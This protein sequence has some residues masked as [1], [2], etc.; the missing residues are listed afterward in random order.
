VGLAATALL[1]FPRLFGFKPVAPLPAPAPAAF[2][3][4]F[5]IGAAF[6]LFFWWLMWKR[7]TV[8]GDLVYYAFSPMWWGF[9]LALDG[10]AYRRSGGK[11]LLATKPRLLFISALVSVAGW[12]FFEFYDYFALANWYYPNGRM[13]QLSHAMIVV[14]FLIAYTTVWPAILEWYALLQTFPR[15]VARYSNGPRLALPGTLL[16]W[17]GLVLIVLMV[18]FPYPFFWAM[19]IGPL[20]ALSGQLIRKNVWSPFTAMAQGNWSPFLLVALASLFNGFF[21][22]IWNYGSAHPSP[23]FQSNPN[24]WVYV[25]P[26]VNVIH[27]FA[28]MPL[29]GYFGYLPFGVLVW[30]MFIWAGKVFGF[31]YDL[32]TDRPA[33]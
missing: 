16:L 13:V 12:L 7:V 28:E 33:P 22:E 2:P 25:I 27:I 29:L 20:I 31:D 15:L 21:W 3:V 19:W 17:G 24:Y 26:Y 4:W 6:T 23:G 8:F 1:L 5:W 30:I 11:S 14:L 9:I 10:W 32:N 18:F